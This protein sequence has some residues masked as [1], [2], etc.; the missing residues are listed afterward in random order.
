MN[1]PIPSQTG[2]TLKEQLHEPIAEMMPLTLKVEVVGPIIQTSKDLM[3]LNG[4]HNLSVNSLTPEGYLDHIQTSNQTDQISDSIDIM[5]EP[6]TE[7][8]RYI[9][10]LLRRE[11]FKWVGQM[12]RTMKKR[13]DAHMF[14]HPV[15]PIAMG[16]PSYF[17]FVPIPIDL[18]TIEKRMARFL[19][20]EV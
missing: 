4:A 8:Q 7:V 12:I 15:D 5:L 17:T 1:I 11:Q 3:H 6:E 9:D 19:Y 18:S 16:I 14:L 13:K 20:T 2:S 10:P